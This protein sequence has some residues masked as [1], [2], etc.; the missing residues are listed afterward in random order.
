MKPVVL[1]AV[2]DTLSPELEKVSKIE[3]R[4]PNLQISFQSKHGMDKSTVGPGVVI[5]SPS[6]ADLDGKLGIQGKVRM[7]KVEANL[8]IDDNMDLV[9]SIAHSLGFTGFEN[10][11]AFEEAVEKHLEKTIATYKRG[12]NELMRERI[13]G[14]G[15]YGV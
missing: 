2:L 1:R 12:E 6:F 13:P 11:E 3:G 4:T 5:R 10:F 7:K 15:K 14:W 9:N 8:E